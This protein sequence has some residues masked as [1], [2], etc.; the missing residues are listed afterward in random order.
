[1]DYSG[2]LSNFQFLIE[3]FKKDQW[4]VVPLLPL[5][6]RPPAYL[7]RRFAEIHYKFIEHRNLETYTC[8]VIPWVVVA[9][10][11]ILKHRAYQI[12]DPHRKFRTL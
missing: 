4:V 9:L 6:P 1:M 2:A 7:R 3:H 10:V 5:R 8:W 11:H 12:A